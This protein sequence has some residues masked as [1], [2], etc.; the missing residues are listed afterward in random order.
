MSSYRRVPT[1]ERIRAAVSDD[2]FLAD[3]RAAR[4]RDPLL[5]RRRDLFLEEATFTKISNDPKL[6]T[7][8]VAKAQ[9]VN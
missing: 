9:V 5:K 7:V 4:F 1:Q 8:A 6:N 2:L 3:L